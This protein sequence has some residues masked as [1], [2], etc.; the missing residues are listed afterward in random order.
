MTDTNADRQTTSG[1]TER[2]R[3]TQSQTD[4]QTTN[5]QTHRQQLDR[6]THRETDN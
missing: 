1:Q 5:R 3:H 6:Q 2:Y 4:T